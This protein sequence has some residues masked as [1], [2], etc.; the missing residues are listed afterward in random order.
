MKIKPLVEVADV[1]RLQQYA[2]WCGWAL[3]RAH[4]KAGD[5]ALISGYLGK[6]GR[7]D[8]AVADFALA[9]ADQNARDHQALRRAIAAGRIEAIQG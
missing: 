4:A 7:F 3:A 9:Y 5:A 8:D 6:S 1:P 2:Q